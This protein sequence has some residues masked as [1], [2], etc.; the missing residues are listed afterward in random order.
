MQMYFFISCRWKTQCG[1]FPI[2]G[3][4]SFRPYAG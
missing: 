4:G 1:S 3:K 2:R